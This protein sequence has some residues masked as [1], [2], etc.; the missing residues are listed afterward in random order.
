MGIA[1]IVLLGLVAL[2]FILVIVLWVKKKKAGE[3]IG[4]TGGACANC[5]KKTTKK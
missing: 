2:W 3:C 5:P 4:C 1:D